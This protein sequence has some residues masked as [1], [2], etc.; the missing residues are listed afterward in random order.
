MRKN[1]KI[2]NQ[3]YS[4]DIDEKLLKDFSLEEILAVL[5]KILKKQK[6]GKKWND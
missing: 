6:S 3:N 4:V 2:N 1:L 5:I